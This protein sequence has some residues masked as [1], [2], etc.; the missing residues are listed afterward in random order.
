MPAPAVYIL[1]VVG[2]IAAGI[3]FK[4]VRNVSSEL[5]VSDLIIV[6]GLVYI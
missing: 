2:T 1:A 4:E 6:G 5:L 3:A